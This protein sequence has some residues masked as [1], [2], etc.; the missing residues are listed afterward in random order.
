[1]SR[2]PIHTLDSAPEASKPRLL[3]LQQSVGMIPNLAAGM[4][5]SPSL[6]E[7]FLAIRETYQNGTFSGAEIEVLSLT[8]AFENGCTWC[9]AFH[10]L[11]ARK[12]GVSA[13]V[14][15]ALRAG[16]SPDDA[17]FGPLSDFARAM[18]RGRGSVGEAERTRFHDAGY[19]P[20]QALEV[21]LGMAFSL[22]ANYS[23]HLVNAPLD[24]PLEAHAW[25]R[26]T[27]H[28]A[29]SEPALA[30]R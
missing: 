18:V 29:H 25:H 12:K 26:A 27:S 20:A 7:G 28:G 5:E 19:T 14:V 22:M 30:A 6:L 4:A 13:E 23:G 3:A 15:N 1:M 11:M 21:V 16:R 8:S 17:R 2:F 24:Q 9:M 10:S